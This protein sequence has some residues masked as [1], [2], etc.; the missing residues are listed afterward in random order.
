MSL[1]YTLLILALVFAFRHSLEFGVDPDSI[2]K[3]F[4]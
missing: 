4:D 2:P 3:I 1:I